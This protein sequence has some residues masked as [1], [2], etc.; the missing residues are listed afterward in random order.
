MK[1][2]IDFDRIQ[3]IIETCERGGIPE[4]EDRAYGEIIQALKSKG[5]KKAG[6][7]TD[8]QR[9]LKRELLEKYDELHGKIPTTFLVFPRI[10]MPFFR[11]IISFCL[12][13]VIGFGMLNFFGT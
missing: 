3:R 12:L 1:N 10:Q 5:K 13:M 11:F 7:D 8:F 9:R 4:P 6:M 2:D